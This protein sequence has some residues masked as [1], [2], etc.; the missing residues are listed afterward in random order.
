MT[1]Q[2][3]RERLMELSRSQLNNEIATLLG[4]DQIR[5]DR[6]G[7]LG[8]NP[9][10]DRLEKVPAFNWDDV[11][12]LEIVRYMRDTYNLYVGLI[13]SPESPEDAPAVRLWRCEMGPG[14]EWLVSANSGS[15]A[16]AICMTALL[17]KYQLAEAQHEVVN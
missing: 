7:W 2:E 5:Y 8:I 4:W 9:E 13:A 11:R 6:M 3:E 15:M 1:Y 10:T 14:I 16:A 17:A 12:A